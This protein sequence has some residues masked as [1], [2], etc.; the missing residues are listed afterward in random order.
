MRLDLGDGAGLRAERRWQ[1]GYAEL[2]GQRACDLHFVHHAPAEQYVPESPPR[3][4]AFGASVLESPLGDRP[5]LQEDL[6]E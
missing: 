6:P 5:A 4:I 3:A 1:E 2:G